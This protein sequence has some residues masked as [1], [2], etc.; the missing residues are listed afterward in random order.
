[1]PRKINIQGVLRNEAG[2]LQEGSLT[3]RVQ[4]FPTSSA[5]EAI[6]DETLDAVPVASGI[7]SIDIGGKTDDLPGKLAS[8]DAPEIRMTVNG[9]ELPRQPLTAGMYALHAKS[10]E[11]VPF[12]GITG[13]P[14]PKCPEGQFLKS[15][16]S[17]GTPE[18][19][20]A[21]TQI[22]TGSGL[23]GGTISN[24]GALSVDFGVVA[25]KNHEHSLNC[26]VRMANADQRVAVCTPNE[27]VTGGGCSQAGESRPA[28]C[29]DSRDPIA[30]SFP[31][32]LQRAVS[33]YCGAGVSYVVCCSSSIR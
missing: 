12:T 8:A 7:F 3:F 9:K 26:I 13:R 11:T 16:S 17:D 1:M 6:L 20:A 19:V 22:T 14:A 24:K 28:M 5:T 27:F 18:C 21:V 25:Q 4:V 33:W 2:A 15:I 10:A 23:I 32:N 31:P 30:C 29:F